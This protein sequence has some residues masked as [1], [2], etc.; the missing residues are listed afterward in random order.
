MQRRDLIQRAL[1]R[2]AALGAFLALAP[3]ARAEP[4]TE[5]LTDGDIYAQGYLAGL[6]QQIEGIKRLDVPSA[7]VVGALYD[8]MGRLTTLDRPV[9][10]SRHH[11]VYGVLDAFEAWARERGLDVSQA[12][13]EHWQERLA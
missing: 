10:V 11:E 6:D 4:A 9:T 8:F 12:D 2:V 7:V 13:V 3:V 1:T 5:S